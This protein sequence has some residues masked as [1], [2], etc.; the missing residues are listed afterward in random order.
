MPGHLPESGL[1]VP[2]DSERV[3]STEAHMSVGWQ[4]AIY[5]YILEHALGYT[6]VHPQNLIA[7]LSP[8]TIAMLIQCQN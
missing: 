4:I 1:M 5:I 3:I 6:T 8:D 2:N 7:C